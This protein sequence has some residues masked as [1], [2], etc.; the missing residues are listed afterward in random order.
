M[1]NQ[2]TRAQFGRIPVL[3][4]LKF[5]IL[6]WN[7][8]CSSKECKIIVPSMAWLSLCCCLIDVFTCCLVIE[9]SKLMAADK[10]NITWPCQNLRLTSCSSSCW[11]AVS[12]AAGQAVTDI[13]ETWKL[14]SL[15]LSRQTNT[16]HTDIYINNIL[17]L[18]ERTREMR[19]CSIVYYSSIS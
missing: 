1:R 17:N 2:R 11:G 19:L 6:R 3:R 18:I 4:G 10:S 12:R 14:H 13:C 16:Q 15:L 8:Y 9:A 7:S 5:L